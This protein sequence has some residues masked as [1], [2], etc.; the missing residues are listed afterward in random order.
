MA[1]TST[2]L[3]VNRKA[4]YEYEFLQ[5]F[6]AGMM[7]LGT[8][9]KSI[10]G[11]DVNLS[12]AYCVIK[13][14][15]IFIKSLFIGEYSHGNSNNHETRRDR[16]LLLRKTEISKIEKKINEKGHTLV[17]YRVFFSD[18]GFA[19]VEI[20]LATGK[21]SY[22]KRQSLKAKDSKRELDRVK[23]AHDMG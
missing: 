11:G 21:K 4:K 20:F 6:E 9:V 8:E 1:G 16:K 7:L 15:E 19:K 14:S 18:R 12:D 22:D 10:R 13:N 2:K 3:I 23:K 17:P 5:G